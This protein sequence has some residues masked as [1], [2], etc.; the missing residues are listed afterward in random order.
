M[1]KF[2]NPNE[3]LLILIAVMG[4]LLAPTLSF[5]ATSSIEKD[6]VVSDRS[7]DC[8][9]LPM[10][11]ERLSCIN[12]N[13]T[14]LDEWLT[15]LTNKE[16]WMTGGELSITSQRWDAFIKTYCVFGLPTDPPIK[17]AIMQADCVN[18]VLRAQLLYV[19]ERNTPEDVTENVG[20]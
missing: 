8:S 10:N 5:G 3:L 7:N 1:S 16:S 20:N 13:T 2:S 14:R 4:L 9:I 19:L 6:Y 11:A 15:V 17:R 12:Q 18:L